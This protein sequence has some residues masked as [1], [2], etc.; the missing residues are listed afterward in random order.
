MVYHVA[1]HPYQFRVVT[2]LN[3]RCKIQI[4]GHFHGRRERCWLLKYASIPIGR[5]GILR[6]RFDQPGMEV[7]ASVLLPEVQAY[8][9]WCSNDAH[10]EHSGHDIGDEWSPPGKVRPDKVEHCSDEKEHDQR[11]GDLYPS[12]K[13]ESPASPRYLLIVFCHTHSSCV[14]CSYRRW[15]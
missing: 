3:G 4:G 9:N 12:D 6:G 8:P 5:I 7:F 11:A 10:H 14:L 13:A 1:Q 15:Y 2:L